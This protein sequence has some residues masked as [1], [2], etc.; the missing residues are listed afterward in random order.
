LCTLL[1]VNI[2]SGLFGEILL[3]REREREKK[4][5]EFFFF[6]F[7][8]SNSLFASPVIFFCF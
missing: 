7:Q 8:F 6:N 4:S 2:A 1:L 5:R 3:T